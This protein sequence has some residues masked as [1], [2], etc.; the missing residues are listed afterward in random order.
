MDR[1]IESLSQAVLLE[2]SGSGKVLHR[3]DK[4]AGQ[5][6]PPPLAEYGFSLRPGS[7]LVCFAGKLTTVLIPGRFR[8]NTRQGNRSPASFKRKPSRVS[9]L[10]KQ[11]S[12]A[13]LVCLARGHSHFL[14]RRFVNRATDLG[15]RLASPN[16]QVQQRRPPREPSWR[17]KPGW[18]PASAA[19]TGS[20]HPVDPSRRP[21]HLPRHTTT[22]AP[23][24]NRIMP[25]GSGTA[26][27]SGVATTTLSNV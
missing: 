13:V 20:A 18:R 15:G 9:L 4:R 7:V 25:E 21:R 22:T 5:A 26:A 1:L 8:R 14:A 2:E 19:T 16:A 3:G 11:R 6:T 23:S 27:T 17:G 24:A 12:P 10:R